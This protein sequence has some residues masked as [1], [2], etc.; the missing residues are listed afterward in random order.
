MKPKSNY[1]KVMA[2]FYIFLGFIAALIVLEVVCF[3]TFYPLLEDS[4]VLRMAA[5][6][7]WLYIGAYAY[8]K[9]TRRYTKWWRKL[10]SKDS[11]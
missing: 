5:T 2:A 1:S 7:V 8:Y 9:L 4:R 3:L 6:A 11:E 10:E